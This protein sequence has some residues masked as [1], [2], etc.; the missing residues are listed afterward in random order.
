MLVPAVVGP[1]QVVTEVA[2]GES[3][4]NA[5]FSVPSSSPDVTRGENEG[6]TPS[7]VRHVT[8]V[9]VWYFVAAQEVK[10]IDAVAEKLTDPKFVP[11][12]VTVVPLLV[13]AFHWKEYETAGASYEKSMFPVPTMLPRVSCAAR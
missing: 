2:T 13:G 10:P 4:V 1:F 6:P 7:G 8:D 9:M 5:L 3:K 12:I 11:C